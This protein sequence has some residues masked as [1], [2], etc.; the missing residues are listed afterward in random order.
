MDINIR[1]YCKE[2]NC[3]EMLTPYGVI[4]GVWKED[5]QPE[6]RR[7][8]VE[9]EVGDVVNC[10]QIT[11]NCDF[12][13]GIFEDNQKILVCGK[14]HEIDKELIIVD[15]NSELIMIDVD[16]IENIIIGDKVSFFIRQL[17]IWDTG[18]V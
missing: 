16:N 7:Y 6:L 9:I 17:Q 10:S 8:I 13:A 14:V 15:V 12:K 18:L 11:K 4:H 5:K 1:A 3:V 2:N